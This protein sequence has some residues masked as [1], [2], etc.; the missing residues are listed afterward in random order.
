MKFTIGCVIVALCVSVVLGDETS[1]QG[2]PETVGDWFD[3]ANWSAGVPTDEHYA[4]IRNSGT[5]SIGYGDA[6]ARSLRLGHIWSFRE[7]LMPGSDLVGALIQTG[8]TLSV[9]QSV[10]IGGPMDSPSSYTL[11]GGKLVADFVG[12]GQMFGNGL[13]TQIGGIS[14]TRHLRVGDL[15]ARYNYS[16]DL[17]SSLGTYDMIGGQLATEQSDVGVAGRG[18]FVQ[19]GGNHEVEQLLHI[20][21]PRTPNQIIF[22]PS[23]GIVL[24]P[25]TFIPLNTNANDIAVTGVTTNWIVLPP[26]YSEGTYELNGGQLT[27]KQ[28]KI[29]KTGTLRQTGGINE[30]EYLS[31]KESGRYEYLGGL[32]NIGSGLDLDGDLDFEGSSVHLNSGGLLNFSR[33]NLLNSENANISVVANSLTIFAGDFDPAASLGSFQSDGLVHFAGNDLVIAAGE[34]FTGWGEIN[35]HVESSGVITASEGGGINL[36]KG[37]LVREGAVNLR[38]GVLAVHNDRSGIHSGTIT[39][40]SMTVG[41]ALF[42]FVVASSSDPI[43]TTYTNLPSLFRQIDGTIN[44]SKDLAVT[45]ATYELHNG[46]LF[47]SLISIGGP[48]GSGAANFMQSGGLCEVETSIVV[49]SY[50][51]YQLAVHNIDVQPWLDIPRI[52]VPITDP[53][54]FL[55]SSATYQISGGELSTESLRI[56]GNYAE[57]RFIQTG[58]AVNV[59]ANLSIKGDD[60][61]YT[62]FGGTLRTNYMNVGGNYGHGKSTLSILNAESQI[63]TKRMKFQRSAKFVAVPGTTI[64]FV[65]PQDDSGEMP[66]WLNGTTFDI[67]SIDPAAMGGLG[68]LT[69]VFE[70]GEDYVAT[71][72]VAGEDRGIGYG[73]FFENFAFDTL[74]IGGD[75]G[76]AHLQLVDL[77]DNQPD[78]EG[79]EALYVKELIL[80][81][82][83]TLDLNGLSLYSL[84]VYLDGT[85]DWNGGTIFEGITE[86]DSTIW[87]DNFD[88]ATLV[89]D[90]NRDGVVSVDDYASVQANLGS[91]G[92]PGLPG[93]ANYD[94]AVSADDYASVQA[95]FGDTAGMG[96]VPVP[97]PTTI[98]L[99]AMGLVAILRKR[100]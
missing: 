86:A 57:A 69:L 29:D 25:E 84:N 33:G 16:E 79:S 21:G 96:G 8:G 59:R 81:E 37:L 13:F 72:E 74:Q 38:S 92:E 85:V 1:W 61:S 53:N 90:A 87:T 23:G 19:T 3:P 73:G 56:D 54:L 41:S 75:E 94:G 51:P 67:E 10:Y 12:V 45:H 78:W 35:D 60:A 64:H 39:A 46:D 44:L 52:I 82:G 26:P 70:G 32:L 80:G 11:I 99:L 100:K 31:I 89:G 9:T 30:V 24:V 47:A 76:A 4:Y 48:Y 14:N 77:F 2:T 28:E 6:M 71:L 17:D 42:S 15:M 7:P 63:I 27:A 83:S 49:G 97:E 20:G 93:D 58:G 55:S 68:N 91:T 50:S 40:Q 34:G 43:G 95:N 66:P 62:M 98:G 18:R 36:R 65:R 22:D 88:L 5:V